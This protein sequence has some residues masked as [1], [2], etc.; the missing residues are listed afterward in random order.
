MRT[1]NRNIVASL[2]AATIFIMPTIAFSASLIPCG[3]PIVN[4]IITASTH[5]CD[6]NDLIVLMN[7]IVHFLIFDVVVPLV[8]LG[9]MFIG[10]NFVLNQDKESARSA[11]KK[12]LGSI[13]T[14]IFWIIASYL[15]V[16]TALF[17]LL[18]NDQI[19][20]MKFIL[21]VTV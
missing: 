19:T 3:D 4:G 21:D 17:A 11:A 20:F 13:V 2:L 5:P 7:T 14:G 1:I 18:S 8:A 15:I 10:A 12:Q 16:K 9:F 6:F